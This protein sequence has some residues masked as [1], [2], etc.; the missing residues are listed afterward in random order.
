MNS[1]K[2]SIIIPVCNVEK[3]IGACLE[4]IYRQGLDEED[5]EI[6]VIDDG[7]ADG[8][9]QIV[10][11]WFYSKDVIFKDFGGLQGIRKMLAF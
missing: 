4:S 2:L 1:I 7:S 9:M 5:F 8:S 3:Y 6:I 10:V 11:G